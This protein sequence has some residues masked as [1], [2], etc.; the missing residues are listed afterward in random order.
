MDQ[1][2]HAHDALK[3]LCV[4]IERFVQHEARAAEYRAPII[5]WHHPDDYGQ[6]G[7][8]GIRKFLA[9][10]TTERDHVA[11]VS[12]RKTALDHGMGGRADTGQL[13]NSGVPPREFTTNA[14][15]ILAVWDEFTHA[16]WPLVVISQSLECGTGGVAK[17]DVVADGGNVWIKVNTLAQFSISIL[18]SLTCSA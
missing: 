15:H 4:D 18:S 6:R 2:K 14:P 3:K 9:Q 1:V 7:I 17:V 16:K 10:A 12:C 8:Q 13:L 11:G 5:D